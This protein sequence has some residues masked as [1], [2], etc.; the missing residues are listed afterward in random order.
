MSKH[1]TQKFSGD[2]SWLKLQAINLKK[3]KNKNLSTTSPRKR[4]HASETKMEPISLN[5]HQDD[6]KSTCAIENEHDEINNLKVQSSKELVNLLNSESKVQKQKYDSS[7]WDEEN[8]K[9]DDV[10]MAFGC[11]A[12]YGYS[13]KL[14]T[15]EA[16][17]YRKRFLDAEEAKIF[18]NPNFVPPSASDLTKKLVK[19][20]KDDIN[21]TKFLAIDCEMVGIGFKGK[22][23]I[24]A[25]V[26]ICNLFGKCIYDKHVMPGA[27]EEVVDYRTEVSGVR[28]QDLLEENGALPFEIVKFEVASLLKNRVLVG[29]QLNSDLK[30][31]KIKH[32]QINIRDTARYFTEKYGNTPSLKRLVKDFLE[33]GFQTGE[34]SSVQD[35]QATMKIYTMHKKQWEKEINVLKEKR[36]HTINAAYPIK[37]NTNKP[38]FL[39]NDS[40]SS[41][42]RDSFSPKKGLQPDETAI[43]NVIYKKRPKKVKK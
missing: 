1:K 25:R 3:S 2:N 36:E 32:P 21:L 14:K 43:V 22:K 37:T 9:V 23:S 10:Q 6:L 12:A 13:Q 31:L 34:H 8:I 38:E 5:Q 4:K 26:S 39:S 18:D 28:R 29:H 35:A 24:L 17:L 40:T 20:T 27:G 19:T 30:V 42:S 7:Q 16:K 33:I 11:E 41:T 15:K